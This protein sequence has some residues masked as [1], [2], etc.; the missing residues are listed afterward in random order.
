MKK[1][2]L[3]IFICQSAF[4]FSQTNN[5]LAVISP[6]TYGYIQG[7]RLDSLDAEYGQLRILGESFTF[8]IGEFGT[9]KTRTVTDKN[10]LALVFP[11]NNF[12]FALNFFYF[13]GW[14]L[15][16]SQLNDIIMLKRRL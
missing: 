15:V 16:P 13:N 3:F 7:I 11:N 1:I 14:E 8:D 12:M 10:G 6:K 9:R 2:F 5:S 4:A